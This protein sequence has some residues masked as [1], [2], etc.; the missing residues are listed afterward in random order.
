MFDLD[1]TLGDRAGAVRAWADGF[2]AERALRD[3]A[4]E[5]MLEIDRDGY[6]D[7][8]EAFGLIRERFAL[9]EHERPTAI[10]DALTELPPLLG[11]G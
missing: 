2:A 7:R 6:R 9:A 1:N 5:W 10:L 3:G 8:V 11:R 4:V